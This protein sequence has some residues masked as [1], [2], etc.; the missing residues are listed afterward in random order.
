[1][2]RYNVMLDPEAWQGLQKLAEQRESKSA[3]EELRQAIDLYL[4]V[5]S[6]VFAQASE[7][8]VRRWPG[9]ET[10]LEIIKRAFETIVID[11]DA[12]GKSKKLDIVLERTGSLAEDLHQCKQ[13]LAWL[14]AHV[15]AL[16]TA[17]AEHG[18]DIED[19]AHG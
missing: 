11:A 14:Q 13:M 3:S 2:Q 7:I 5:Q 15:E 12:N 8:L 16:E 1:M 17:F 9:T 6:D 18:F 10:P 19:V 4:S